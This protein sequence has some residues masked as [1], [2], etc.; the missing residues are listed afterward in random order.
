M[1][2][3]V[4]GAGSGRRLR[5]TLR[6]GARG[7]GRASEEPDALPKAFVSLAGR[8]LLLRSLQALAASEEVD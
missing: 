2:A 5:E 3:L 7:S 8:C 6:G 4:L 1:A